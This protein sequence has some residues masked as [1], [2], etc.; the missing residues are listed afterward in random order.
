MNKIYLIVSLIVTLNVIGQHSMPI[1]MDTLFYKY[2]V[3]GTGILD[4]GSTSIKN[5]L[6]KKLLYG[7]FIDS[8]M[9]E[10]SLNSHKTQNRIGIEASGEIEFRDYNTRLF[11]QDKY[12]YFIR[13]GYYNYVTSAYSQD[14]FNLVFNGNSAFLGDTANF[15]G[16]Q[17]NAISLQKIGFGFIDKKSK[18]NIGINYYNVSN[19]SDAYIRSGDLIMDSTGTNLELDMGARF[20]YSEGKRFNKGWGIGIDADF[21][22]PVKWLNESQAYIQVQLKNIGFLSIKNMTEYTADE[23]YDFSGFKFNQL[24]GDSTSSINGSSELLD[25]LGIEKRSKNITSMLPGFI[26]IGKIVDYQSDK[27]VQSYFGVRLHTTLDYT[28]L[29]YIGA[30]IKLYK[31]MKVGIQGSYGGFS[32]FRLGFYS[33]YDFGKF[34]FGIGSEDLIG[35]FSNKG[36]GES[37]HFRITRLW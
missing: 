29:A 27:T 5:E 31:W 7:G 21:R 2:E 18:S 14:V 11:N 6:S 32:N 24:I 17:A 30:H 13:G 9:K 33:Q 28:P 16:T 15:S 36:Y 23:S 37:I 26:Q 4:Y 35:A 22:I 19:L 3:I 20:R 25:T 10:R 34:H 12:G 1:Q 8:D